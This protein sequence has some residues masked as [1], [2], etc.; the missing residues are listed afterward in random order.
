MVATVLTLKYRV[1]RHQ[2]MR[3]WWRA[4][5][6]V[7]GAVWSL[8]LIPAAFWMQRML[9]LEVA[10]VRS[11]I[12]VG[13]AA[14][15]I[16]G[17]IVVPLL[18]TGL[19]DT[20]DPGRFAIFGVSAR[21]IMPGLTIAAAL[22][23]PA[24]FF[25]AVFMILAGSWRYDGSG[26][27]ALAV[28]GSLLTVALMALGA[29]V[30]VAWSTRAL[31]S[32]RTRAIALVTVVAS[33]GAVAP[34]GFIVLRAGIESAAS[35]ELPVVLEWLGRTPVG[36]GMVAP[37]AL[38][39]GDAWGA[40]WRVAMMVA[41]VWIL[42]RA[43]QDN[44]AYTL[45]HPLHRGGGAQ[46]RSDAVLAGAARRTLWGPLG[47]DSAT[48]AVRARALL[49]WATDPRYLVGSVGVVALPLVFFGLV[50]PMLDLD[51]RWA[52]GAPVI[53]AASIGWGRHND[54]A[55]DSSALWM[56]VVAGRIGR[57]V[58]AARTQ[59]VLVWAL[60]AVGLAALA[61][62]AWSR[63][64]EVAPGLIGACVG[65]LGATL[66]ISAVTSVVLPYRAPGPG[67]NPFGAEVG[68]VGASLVAQLISGAAMFA[69][70]PLVTAPFV[71]A[72][73]VDARW[74]WVALVTGV[75]LGVAACVAGVRVAGSW[76]DR[77]SGRLLA[78]VS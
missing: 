44:V 27:V 76:Y 36:A 2:L 1:V 43:W 54:V 75:V 11:Q 21:S 15:C 69:I 52:F 42:H 46:R 58:M 13:A 38:A 74:G 73:A 18:V 60:P 19:E 37:E 22:T 61:I 64:W 24:L 50:V 47:S 70:L 4:L 55:Y 30:A 8:S 10:D 72:L 25:I 57:Q 40:A 34:A 77:R 33:L 32:R 39:S 45:V 5:L 6:L 20:L 28:V 35:Y 26:V 68:S 16:L 12:L 31:R 53:L 49:Y 7:G 63:L 23:V 56:D 14:V 67:E 48:R 62:L 59:A 66:G 78:G 71:L 29:R 65:A 41:A 9:S 17:W 51:P 3:E